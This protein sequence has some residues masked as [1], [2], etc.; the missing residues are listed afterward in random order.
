MHWAVLLVGIVLYAVRRDVHECG[1]CTR[2]LAKLA[3]VLGC[4]LLLT[5]WSPGLA[6]V[7][8]TQRYTL[9]FVGLLRSRLPVAGGCGT[10][11]GVLQVYKPG[12]LGWMRAGESVDTDL[13]YLLVY[14]KG[15]VGWPAHLSGCT[16][17]TI[18]EGAGPILYVLICTTRA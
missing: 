13:I 9:S 8:G 5:Q 3:K 2:L 18:T 11:S 4:L 15:C 17:G 7:C 6:L 16:C 14:A 10:V 1:T 12:E